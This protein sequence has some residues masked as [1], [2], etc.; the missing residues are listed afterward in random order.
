M[1]E[2]IE[3][4]CHQIVCACTAETFSVLFTDLCPGRYVFGKEHTKGFVKTHSGSVAVR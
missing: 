3:E 1:S 4:M 2:T